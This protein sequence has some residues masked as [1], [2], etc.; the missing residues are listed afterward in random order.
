M[1]EERRKNPRYCEGHISLCEDIAVIKTTVLN[2]D[3]GINGSIDTIEKHID[4]SRGRN[5]AIVLVFL[6]MIGWLFTQGIAWGESK[7]QTQIN[8][9]RWNYLI[10]GKTPK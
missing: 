8:T 5:L 7:K 4:N 1:E 2:L 3:K 9:E 6:G 10:E